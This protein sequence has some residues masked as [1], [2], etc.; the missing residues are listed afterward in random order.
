MTTTQGSVTAGN[1]AGNMTVAVDV[2]TVPAAGSVTIVF[3]VDINNPVAAGVMQISNQGRVSSNELPVTLTDD[4]SQTG[5]SNP[6]ITVIDAEVLLRASKTATLLVDADG[7]GEPSPGDTLLYQV[8]VTNVG[9]TAATNVTLT[10]SPDNNTSLVAGSVATSRGSVT[11]GNGGAPPVTVNFGTIAGGG[12]S[13]TV[14]FNVTINDPLPANVTHVANQGSVS[15]DQ[16]PTL[17]TDDPARPGSADPTVTNVTAAPSILA[18]K[19]ATE[20]VDVDDDGVTSPGDTLLYRVT[21][22]NNG[23]AAGSAIVFNDLPG[24]NQLLVAGSVQTGAGTVTQ[25]NTPG[26]TTATV[27]VGTIPGNGASVA[28]RSAPPSTIRSP[29]ASRPF[30]IKALSPARTSRPS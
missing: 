19:V 1:V 17:E 20:V 27:A 28:S 4:P 30:A 14:S 2:G 25:G 13:V 3:L 18:T 9:N 24:P 10:D 6:T 11:D 29:P 5:N 15:S 8:Q 7:D 26:D 21:I 12:D 22:T 23:N 16:S